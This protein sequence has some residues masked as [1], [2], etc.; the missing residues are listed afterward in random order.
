MQV[1]GEECDAVNRTSCGY[2]TYCPAKGLE[3]GRRGEDDGFAGFSFSYLLP[4]PR[5]TGLAAIMRWAR[6]VIL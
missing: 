2:A 3:G 1:E 6:S 4:P 5:I